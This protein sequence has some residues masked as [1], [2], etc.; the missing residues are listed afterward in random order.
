[1]L[2]GGLILVGE[3]S[4]VQGLLGI[5]V[6]AF[7]LLLVAV[8]FPYAVYWDNMLGDVWD[9]LSVCYVGQSLLAKRVSSKL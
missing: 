5:L 6:C 7:W 8:K 3:H 1:M 2:T 9:C 4:T